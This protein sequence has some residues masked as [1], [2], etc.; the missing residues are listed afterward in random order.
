MKAP[1]VA[2][3]LAA[4]LGTRMRPL[5]ET[6]PK[7]LVALSGKTLIDHVL[8]R[9]AAA[10]VGKAVVNVHYLAD[11][12]EAHLAGREEPEITISDERDEI[13][14]TG[15]G[16]V[17]ALDLLGGES[18][19]VHNSDSVWVE[20]ANPALEAMIAGW[21]AEAMDALLLLAPVDRAVGYSGAGDFAMGAQGRPI[22]R[23]SDKTAPFVFAGVS[24]AHPRLLDGM[25]EGP[26]SLNRPWD[27]AIEAGRLFGICHEGTWMHVGTPDAL[28]EAETILQAG[29]G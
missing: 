14:D 24:I 20:G 17:R 8:D 11:R 1:R 15:G 21:D 12:I 2:M 4:G 23:G 27:R 5:T 10:G 16:V 29:D 28:A 26:F 13:L 3:V 25:P 18:F 22:R 9:L 6:V 7:P 19:F